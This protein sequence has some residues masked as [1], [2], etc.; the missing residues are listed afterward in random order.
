M[1][2]LTLSTCCRRIVKSY[3]NG[4]RFVVMGRLVEAGVPLCYE[5][6]V[7]VNPTALTPQ[8]IYE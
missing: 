6:T 1:A 8:N 4:Y 2:V 3:P 5:R 7:T